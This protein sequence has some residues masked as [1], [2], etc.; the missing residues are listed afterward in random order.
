MSPTQ[1][2]VSSSVDSLLFFSPCAA[3]EHC[4]AGK[5]SLPPVVSSGFGKWFLVV[6]STV[7]ACLLL[8]LLPC[9]AAELIR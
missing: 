8:L 4:G 3:A 1:I 9:A 2:G 5:V 6:S 7:A